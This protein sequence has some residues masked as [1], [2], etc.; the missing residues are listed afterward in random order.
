MI[1]ESQTSSKVV[2]EPRALA[3]ARQ[4]V[5]E[6]IRAAANGAPAVA[7]NAVPHEVAAAQVA[8]HAA[9]VALHVEVAQAAP[10]V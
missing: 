4:V 9:L 3:V 10:H 6:L 7:Q 1:M 2:P 8:P 5:P